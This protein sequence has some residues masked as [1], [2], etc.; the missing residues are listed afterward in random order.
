MKHRAKRNHHESTKTNILFL[1][2][3]QYWPLHLQNEPK[4]WKKKM[5][6]NASFQWIQTRCTQSGFTTTTFT[7]ISLKNPSC[8]I[9]CYANRN[10]NRLFPM[11]RKWC[12]EVS[13]NLLSMN[14]EFTD[15][16]GNELWLTDKKKVEINVCLNFFCFFFLV[17]GV[18]WCLTMYLSMLKRKKKKIITIDHLF[19]ACAFIFSGF[20]RKKKKKR[21]L[22]FWANDIKEKC[23]F[24][25]HLLVPIIAAAH[26]FYM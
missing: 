18:W 2:Y 11:I 22:I 21:V 7:T 14:S 12:C 13:A 25:S 20:K 10:C 4:V 19:A 26:S 16:D 23:I 15:S 8:E 3:I 1:N 9:S 6:E 5:K 17:G 24:S